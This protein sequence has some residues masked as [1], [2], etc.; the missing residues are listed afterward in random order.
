MESHNKVWRYLSLSRFIWLLQRKQLWLSRVDLLE[1]PWECAITGEEMSY[2]AQRAP[3]TPVGA[4]AEAV[5]QRLKRITEEWRRT[6][7]INCWC[8]R[9]EESHA[10]WRVFCGPKEG[11]AICSTWGKLMDLAQNM[12]LVEVD[13]TGYDRVRTPNITKV[14]MRKRQMYDYEQEVRIIAQQDTPNPN[15]IKEESG[16]RLGFEPA[17]FIDVIVV[18]PEADDSFNQVVVGIVDTYAPELRNDV[19]WSVM[20]EQ[21]PA[22]ILE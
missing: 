17:D 6:T 16:F 20:R 2:L 3:I 5:N 13:Y 8:G 12:R 22:I 10:L 7:Y 19:R 14:S 9:E 21:P 4:V 11:V 15:L 1:D 18:H